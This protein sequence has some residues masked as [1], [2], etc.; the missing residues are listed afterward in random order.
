MATR[1]RKL[2]EAEVRRRLEAY[3]ENASTFDLS[4][5]DVKLKDAV[6]KPVLAQDIM[7]ALA[8]PQFHLSSGILESLTLKIPW[9]GLRSE[10]IILVAD[11]AFV[12]MHAMHGDERPL[13][14]EL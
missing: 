14:Y 11:G 4:G 12:C 9:S 5:G 8:L 1:V 6:I 2:V 10:P 7:R 13:I 3:I